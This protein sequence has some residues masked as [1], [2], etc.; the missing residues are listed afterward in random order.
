LYEV[1]GGYRTN[2]YRFLYI[3]LNIDYI[4]AQPT[5]KCILDEVDN[6][7]NA[8][9]S[10]KPLDPIYDRIIDRLKKQHENN[11]ALALK[12]LSWLTKARRILTIKELQVAVSVEPD[13]PSLN[14]DC[15]PDEWTLVDICAGLVVID[16]RSHTIRLTH[17]TTRDYLLRKKIIRSDAD[18]AL[19]ISCITYLSFDTFKVACESQD[20]VKRRFSTYPMLEYIAQN[21]SSHLKSCDENDTKS[22]VLKFLGSAGNFLSYLQAMHVTYSEPGLFPTKSSQLHVASKIG[23]ET[24]VQYLLAN[25]AEVSAIDTNMRVPLHLAAKEGHVVIVRLLLDNGFDIDV[26]DKHGST[27]LELAVRGGH[28]TVIRLLLENGSNVHS[29]N[30]DQWTILHQAAFR[31][32]EEVVQMLLDKGSHSDIHTKTSRGCTPLTL[33]KIGGHQAVVRM[34][35]SWGQN[36]ALGDNGR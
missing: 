28:M 18:R 10:E 8:R 24:V 27:P 6:L 3:S 33:A 11:A 25:R 7:K 36:Q 19:A 2:L 4:C 22:E 34:I 35:N 29:K 13:T 32:N 12:A 14:D 30:K 26:K 9:T 1:S 15:V 5:I 20:A 21:T 31:G 17:D 23:H 16:E